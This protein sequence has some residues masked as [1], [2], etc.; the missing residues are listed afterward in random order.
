MQIKYCFTIL[1]MCVIWFWYL[2]CE[3]SRYFQFGII[4]PGYFVHV[5]LQNYGMNGKYI[6]IKY[7]CTVLESLVV[8]V[9]P[10]DC[11]LFIYF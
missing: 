11:E 10:V 4:P 2:D 1:E 3:L 6:Q 7:F 9:V 5:M 8:W